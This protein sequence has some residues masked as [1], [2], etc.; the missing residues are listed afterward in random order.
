MY[1]I[2]MEIKNIQRVKRK[3]EDR[4]VPIGL[5]TSKAKSEFMKAK[6]ISPTRLFNLSLDELIAKNPIK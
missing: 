2:T 5:R 1:S 4:S 6:N 3:D